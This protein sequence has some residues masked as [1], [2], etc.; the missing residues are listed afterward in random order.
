MNRFPHSLAALWKSGALAAALLGA[1]GGPGCVGPFVSRAPRTEIERPARGP[2]PDLSGAATIDSPSQQI[3]PELA[4]PASAI[5][6]WLVQTRACEQVVVSNPWPSLTV[7][8]LDEHGGPLQG[9]RP[10][11]LL[12]RMAGRPVV[13]L[14]HGNGYTYRASVREAI[15]V[16]GQLEANGGLTPE[17][18]FIIFD[19]PSERVVRNI[20]ADLNEKNRRTR[21][22]SYH[23][24]RSRPADRRLYVL[25]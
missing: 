22:A 20:V 14:V 13:I 5:E 16:R 21:V 3:D 7:G 4:S 15:K 6:T 2:G 1:C 17:S 11:D 19:W 24:P 10:E 9:A 25:G 18:L 8:R 23:L 12:E